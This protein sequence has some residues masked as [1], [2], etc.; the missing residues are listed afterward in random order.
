MKIFAG[1]QNYE[2]Q[3]MKMGKYGVQLRWIGLALEIDRTEK[4]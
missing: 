3:K 2:V 1:A 4:R